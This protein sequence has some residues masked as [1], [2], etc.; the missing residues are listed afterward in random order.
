MKKGARGG[1]SWFRPAATL[2]LHRFTI[3]ES[4]DLLDEFLH[5]QFQ[6]GKEWVLVLHGAKALSPVVSRVLSR[7]PLVE[8]FEPDNPGAT[9]VRLG[10]RK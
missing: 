1:A 4:E 6:A 9:R 8:D 7:H 10:R 3:A 5:R 2:D